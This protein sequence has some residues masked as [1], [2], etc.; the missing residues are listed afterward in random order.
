MDFQTPEMLVLFIPFSIFILWYW[1]KRLNY[2][3]HSLPLSSVNLISRKKG[4]RV[5]LYPVLPPLL[6]FISAGLIIFALARPGNDISFSEVSSFGVDIMIAKDVSL[7]ML[8]TDFQPG[9]RLEVSKKLIKKFITDRSTDRIGMVVFAGEA[10]IQCPMTTDYAILSELVDEVDF[11]SVS[12][13]GTAIGNAIALSVARM[14][15]SET[16]SKII[17]LI[18][19]GSSNSGIIEPEDAARIAAEKGI[20]I[21]TVGIGTKGD[22]TIIVPHG[23]KAGRYRGSGD[24]DEESLKKISEITGGKFF[25]ATTEAEFVEYID[26]INMLEKSKFTIKQYHEFDGKWMK[27]LIAA[28]LLFMTEVLLRVLFFRKI[29]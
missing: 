15:D 26:E 19:D 8:G 6:R 29:P 12:E 3:E 11:D 25:R 24:Y 22:Y 27:Y 13:E 17:I 23:P 21:Y 20:K 18:T 4:L 2:R 1:L 10:Y 14:S 9:N 7:S 28:A 5:R 16:K